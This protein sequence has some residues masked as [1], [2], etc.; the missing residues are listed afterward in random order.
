[1]NK[2]A[3]KLLLAVRPSDL[4]TVSLALGD[5]F[6][7]VITHRFEEAKSRLKADIGLI[8]CGVHFD[9]GMMF[10]LLKAARAH[11]ITQSTPFYVL[12][13]EERD[14]SGPMIDGMRSASKLLGATDFIDLLKMEQELGAEGARKAIRMRIREILKRSAQTRS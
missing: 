6:D 2:P 8:A 5:G 9:D 14:Y 13:K 11:P 1:M 4:P 7:T 12:F 3:K 10:E